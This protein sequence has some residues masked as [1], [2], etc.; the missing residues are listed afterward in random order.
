MNQVAPDSSPEKALPERGGFRLRLLELR[1]VTM[2]GDLGLL[3]GCLWLCYKNG[4]IDA[5]LYPSRLALWHTSLS[6]IWLLVSEFWGAYTLARLMP[7]RSAYVASKA[8]L[9]TILVYLLVP[10]V[11]PILPAKRSFMIAAFA[12]PTGLMFLWR[13]F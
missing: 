9:S 13:L 5:R 11:T 3:N 6:L 10:F 7:R 1:L 12:L 2:L 4:G 8:T